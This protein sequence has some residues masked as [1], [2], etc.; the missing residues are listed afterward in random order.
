[1]VRPLK[2]IALRRLRSPSAGP[3]PPGTPRAFPEALKSPTLPLMIRDELLELYAFKFRQGG[4]RR[5]GLTFE[6]FLLA[7]AAINPRDFEDTHHDVAT[8]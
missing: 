2:A 3:V 8:L 4:F 5:A 6:Q 1:M 7:A